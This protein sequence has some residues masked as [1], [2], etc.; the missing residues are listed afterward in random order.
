MEH[1]EHT[2]STA[3]PMLQT[4]SSEMLHDQ[5]QAGSK[6]TLYAVDIGILILGILII[7]VLRKTALGDR[8]GKL[9]TLINIGIIAIA[10][11]H[12]IDTLFLHDLL[13][14]KIIWNHQAALLGHHLGNLV[15]F[16]LIFIGYYLANKNFRNKNLNQK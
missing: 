16:F 15:G 5:H 3:Q 6:T 13:A 12:F 10:L 1:E 7:I 8:L 11:N 14:R 2:S 4:T 9:L